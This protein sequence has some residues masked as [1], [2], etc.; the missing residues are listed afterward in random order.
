M[1]ADPDQ[2]GGSIVNISSVQAIRSTPRTFV[3]A[4]TKG[5]STAMARQ[6]AIEYAAQ[7]IR[8][9]AVLPG[10]ILTPLNEQKFAAAADPDAARRREAWLAPIGRL[11]RSEEV[12]ACVAW[13]LGPDASF[14]TGHELGVDGGAAAWL[15]SSADNPD[16]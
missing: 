10:A 12:A 6:V 14:V 13:L 3:Y 4:A 8:A 1:I 16:L 15:T 7:G 5:A 9:N 2:R 11:G